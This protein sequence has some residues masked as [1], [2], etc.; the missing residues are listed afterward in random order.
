MRVLS[1]SPERYSGEDNC[2]A[3]ALL[4]PLYCFA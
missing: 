1:T 3:L 4:E 2:W